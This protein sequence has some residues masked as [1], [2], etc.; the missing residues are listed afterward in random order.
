M[1]KENDKCTTCENAVKDFCCY[2]RANLDE[3]F[4]GCETVFPSFEV[5]T[6]SKVTA[7]LK[8]PKAY[9]HVFWLQSGYGRYFALTTNEEGATIEVTA[10]FCKAGELHIIKDCFLNGQTIK[11]KLQL[12]PG[13]VIIPF[14]K[15]YFDDLKLNGSEI[16][17]IANKIIGLEKSQNLKRIWMIKMKPRDRYQEFLRLFGSQIEQCFA[18][19]DIANYLGMQPSFLSRLR[20]EC[21]KN[22]AHL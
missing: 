12:A 9:N 5:R 17:V 2:M 18:V 16:A 1:T 20:A 3:K 8:D 19:K 22:K 15:K 7:I 6:L 21:L 14:Q 10:D 4:A 11:C 13:T